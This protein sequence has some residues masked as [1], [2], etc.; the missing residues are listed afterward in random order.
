MKPTISLI[1]YLAL[2][3]Q[4]SLAVLASVN[5]DRELFGLA[6]FDENDQVQQ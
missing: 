6:L 1:E 2:F 3:S 5:A 4:V